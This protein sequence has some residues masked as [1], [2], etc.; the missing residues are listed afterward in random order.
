MDRI[1]AEVAAAFDGVTRLEFTGD[2]IAAVREPFAS[3][4]FHPGAAL[5]DVLAR[6]ITAQLT[7]P[8]LMR[9]PHLM[10]RTVR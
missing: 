5:H 6:E 4:G 1:S 3:D 7:I 9:G 2:E 8:D 10:R